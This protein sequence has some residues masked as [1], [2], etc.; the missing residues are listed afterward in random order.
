MALDSRPT[1]PYNDR[2][3]FET[4][5]LYMRKVFPYDSGTYICEV[6][7]QHGK[8]T[9]HVAI[10][11]HV[12]AFPSEPFS[13]I[14]DNPM[15]IRRHGTAA[16]L[17]CRQSPDFG[18]NPDVAWLFKKQD[19]SEELVYFKGQVAGRSFS[20]VTPVHMPLP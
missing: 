20:F 19:G 6:T 8:R 17:L 15:I 10:Q 13:V 5:R 9:G 1:R 16:D 14:A 4:N 18:P 7:S 11:L 3:D 2:I 12:K